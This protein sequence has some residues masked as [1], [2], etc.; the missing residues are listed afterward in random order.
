MT[1]D[2]V[3]GRIE[4][5]EK[6]KAKAIEEKKEQQRIRG[7]KA[8]QKKKSSQK[9]RREEWKHNMRSYE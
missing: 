3:F 7:D 1:S 9:S 5:A 6:A 2:E 8:L 4:E